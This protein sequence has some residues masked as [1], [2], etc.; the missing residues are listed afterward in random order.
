MERLS[1]SA[2]ACK[3]NCACIRAIRGGGGISDQYNPLTRLESALTADSID[4]RQ[5]LVTLVLISLKQTPLSRNRYN[6]IKSLSKSQTDP[7][8]H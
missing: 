5:K 7:E 6:C 3:I 2:C 8:R 4:C 1:T